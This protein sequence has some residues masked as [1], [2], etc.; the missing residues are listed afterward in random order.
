MK[1][2]VI[3]INPEGCIQTGYG[4]VNAAHYAA[5][6]KISNLARENFS[7]VFE[8]IRLCSGKDR[9][10]VEAIADDLGLGNC[11]Q[12]IAGGSYLFNPTTREIKRHP[13]I[14]RKVERTFRRILKWRV[15]RILRR[16]EILQYCPGELTC[17]TLEKKKGT[18]AGIERIAER[19]TAREDLLADWIRSGSVTTTYSNNA[20][21]IVPPMVSTGSAVKFLAELEEIDLSMSLAIGSSA[22]DFPLFRC[23]GRTGCPSNASQ[24]CQEVVKSKRGKVSL[25][26]YASGA[27]EII[28]WFMGVNK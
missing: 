13:A 19:I 18:L 17:I 12:I 15:P 21:Y 27:A 11:W 28:E 14:N 3:F 24:E 16:W 23:V 9:S 22:A 10:Y 26:H 1:R 8:S 6:A 2:P 25:E 4:N 5:L 7:G 20:I